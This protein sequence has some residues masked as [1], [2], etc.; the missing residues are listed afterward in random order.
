MV[1]TVPARQTRNAQGSGTIRQRPD[2]RWE[3]RYTVG[4]DP[5]TGKQIQRSIYGG[6]QKEVRQRLTAALKDIDAGVY[7]EPS[8]LTVGRWLDIWLAEYVKPAAKPNT[9]NSY[10]S[11]VR[12]RLKPAFGALRLQQ[13][14]QLELQKFFNSLQS[15]E[16]PVSPKTIKNIHGILHKALATAAELQYIPYNP[17]DHVHLPKV[18]RKEIRPLEQEDIAALLAALEREEYRNVYLLALFTGMREGEVL[19][20]SWDAVDFD[21]GSIT[22]K[23]QLLRSKTKGGEYYFGTPKN[24]KGR[25][26]LPARFVMETLREEKRRQNQN[27]LKAGSAWQNADNLVFTDALGRHLATQTV[28]LRYKRLA[29]S[30]GRP[31]SRFHDLRHTYAVTALQEGDDI[32]TVQEALGHATASF[33]LDVYGHVSE[34]MKQASRQRMDAFIEKLQQA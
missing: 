32:K 25:V 17:A 15:G 10:E 27:R 28:F 20:L 6:T 31:E 16:K 2:G 12:C 9:Y 19:G 22:V 24:G 1:K 30:I 8:R 11:Q 21:A 13:L 23:Q 3:A 34:K 33:T 4:R 26:I 18:V 7:Q 29:A 14:K 5:G